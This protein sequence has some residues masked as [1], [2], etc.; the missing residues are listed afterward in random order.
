MYTEKKYC[1]ICCNLYKKILKTLR[2]INQ[3]NLKGRD[4]RLAEQ[5]NTGKDF[6]FLQVNLHI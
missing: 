2:E 5:T 6:V 1:E 3:I 4:Q